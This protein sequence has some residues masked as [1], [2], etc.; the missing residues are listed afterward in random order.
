MVIHHPVFT[1]L[2]PQIM[3]GYNTELEI[4]EG[5]TGIPFVEALALCLCPCCGLKATS[6]LSISSVY[7]T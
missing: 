4:S 3:F 6:N 7:L 2:H 1:R 5:N